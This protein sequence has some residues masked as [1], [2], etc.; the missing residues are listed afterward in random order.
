MIKKISLVL[1]LSF[2]GVS[3]FAQ[4]WAGGVDDDPIHFGF[5][6]Q[7][8]SSEYKIQKKADWRNPYPNPDVPG[9]NVTNGLNAI[10]SPPTPGFGLGFVVNFRLSEHADIR[11]TPGL[12]FTDRVLDYQFIPPESD[13]I[14]DPVTG[15]YLTQ[16]PTSK[17]VQATMVDVPVGL[18]LKSDRRNNFRAYLLLGAKYSRDIISK[19]KIDD[20]GNSLLEKYVKNQRNILSYEAGVGFDL[21]F[22]YFKLSPELKFSQSYNNV[23]KPEDHPFSA[24]LDKLFLRNV[25]FSLFFE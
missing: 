15:I 20:S 22:E 3:A 19:K 11:L 4:N 17:K 2:A 9:S 21:Y 16:P 24:P 13:V 18:K 8:I 14:V 23:L 7:Y 10:S 5:M 12:G 6:F 25:Q 1:L